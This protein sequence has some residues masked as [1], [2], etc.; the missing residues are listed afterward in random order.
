MLMCFC[1]RRP[2]H[3]NGKQDSCVQSGMGARVI[4]TADHVRNYFGA[5]RHGR[6]SRD[7]REFTYHP[8]R[9]VGSHFRLQCVSLRGSMSYV[10][11][12]LAMLSGGSVS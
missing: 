9:S 10:Q 4:F 12:S 8:S 11:K 6:S 7:F 1:V 3:P 2:L 5:L